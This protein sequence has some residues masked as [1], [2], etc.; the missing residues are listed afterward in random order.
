MLAWGLLD[1]K[2]LWVWGSAWAPLGLRTPRE[3]HS[4][5]LELQ[6]PGGGQLGVLGNDSLEGPLS[7]RE[8]PEGRE[9]DDGPARAGPLV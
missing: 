2:L 5:W 3:G 1:V 7:G 6:S 4:Q 9:W 8:F